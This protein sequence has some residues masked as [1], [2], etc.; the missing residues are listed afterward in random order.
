[1]KI[2]VIGLSPYLVTSRS[3]VSSLIMRYLYVKN[4]EVAGMVWAHD[5]NYF[6]PNDSGKLTYK[7]DIDSQGAHEIPIVSFKRG[8]KEVVAVYEVLKSME[9]DMV[10]T[11]GDYGDFLYMKAVKM[12]YEKPFKWLFVLMNYSSPIR[13]ADQELIN[14]TDGVLC[15]SDFAWKSIKDFYHKDNAVVQYVGG[16]PKYYYPQ[17]VSKEKF[18]VMAIG[19]PIQ[20]DNLP[21]IMEAAS[22]AHEQHSDIELYL[23]TSI[24]DNGDYDL[25]ELRR[26][27]DPRN[28]F[29]LFPNK[30]VSLTEEIT[31]IELA[32]EMNVADIFTSVSM[33][34]ATSIGVFDAIS[35]GCFPILSDAGSN[36]DVGRLLGNYLEGYETEDFILPCVNLITVGGSSLG[37][38]DPRKL[39]EK[40]LLAYRN[41]KK[42]K[43]CRDQLS[44]FINKYKRT[45]FLDGLYEM[46]EKT[47]KSEASLCLETIGE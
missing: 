40:I 16:N 20:A 37:V 39:A 42:N 5:T 32:K 10:I 35:C 6:P 21:A 33:A 3:K 14:E 12:C 26:R 11:V 13:E 22:I 23:Q 34:S 47:R 17:E 4:F 7:F 25:E 38:C 28:E 18:R 46:I 30:Y 43:G 8:E 19:K 9:P 2:L 27:F 31:D 41:R 1:M 15:V 45:D 24:Y 29:I 44:Q 36:A